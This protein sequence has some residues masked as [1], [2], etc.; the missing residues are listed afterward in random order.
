ML[1]GRLAANMVSSNGLKMS[2]FEA[3]AVAFLEKDIHES[4]L[5]LS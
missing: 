3:A 2:L 1:V 4:Y 5:R